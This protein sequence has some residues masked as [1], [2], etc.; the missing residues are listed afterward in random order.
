MSTVIRKLKGIGLGFMACLAI[1]IVS[2]V[3]GNFLPKVGASLFAILLGI[4]LGNTVLNKENLAL[5]VKFSE[6]RLLEYSIAL[7]GLTLNLTDVA[8]VGMNGVLFIVCQML[9]TIVLAYQFGKWFGFN[10]RFSLLMSAGNAVCGSSAIGT[11]SPIIDADEK[12]KGISITIVN[13][14][15]TILM[16]ALPF[17]TNIL[18]HH[19]VMPTSAMIGGTLQSVG[20]VIASGKMVGEEVTQYG[21][22]FKIIRII[23]I[24]VVAIS[25][26]RL[27]SSDQGSLFQT[28][29]AKKQSKISIP[30]FI[31]A[32]FGLCL[33]V[34]FVNLPT[35]ISTTAKTVSGQ[36]EIIALAGIGM[37]V[38]FADLIKEGPKAMA[39]GGVIGLSQLIVAVVLIALL[40]NR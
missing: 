19:E 21:T 40:I 3:I 36:F 33:V 6:S 12:D 4:V 15:G 24:V 8:S 39:L 22:I 35:V 10:R 31:T 34:T 28:S 17:L 20:Q 1:G 32:F 2:Q 26:S 9:F 37:R 30:W 23:L 18:Y 5:G 29:G 27:N 14:T 7:T 25:F 16:V 38:K 13:L 11:V